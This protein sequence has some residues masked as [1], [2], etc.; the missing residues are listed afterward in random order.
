MGDWP[1]LRDYGRSIAVVMGTW[2][3]A[4]L[5]PV[6]A[7]EHSLRRMEQLLA[8]PLC[9]WPRERIQVL[10]NVPS[11]GDLPDR[12]ITAFDSVADVAV[13]YFV[14]HGQISP[15]DQLCLGLAQSRPEPNRRA[16]TSLRF[17]DV[18]QALQESI[19][20]VKIVILDC[21]FAGLA[22]RGAMAGDVLDL[23]VGTGAYT[24]AA[25]SAY[26]TAWYEDEPGLNS[27]Q[28]Y[29]TKYLADLVEKGIAG[30]P[31]MLRIDPLF[32]QLR[33][34]L[35]TDGRPVPYSRA[36]ND[37]REYVFAY[38]A[39]P[40]EVQ[41]DP[42]QELARLGQQFERF[43][44]AT[45]AEVNALKAEA[46]EREEELARLR[47]LLASSGPRNAGQQRQLESA[48]DEATRRLDDTRAAQAALST[49]DPEE[50]A[51]RRDRIEQLQARLRERAAAQ[52]WEA[53]IDLSGELT[54][55]DPSAADPDGLANTARH[56]ISRR[57]QTQHTDSPE[58]SQS[59][60]PSRPEANGDISTLERTADPEQA[61]P[62][63]FHAADLQ[64]GMLLSEAGES[65]HRRGT[66]WVKVWPVAN[67]IIAW[68]VFLTMLTLTIGVLAGWDSWAWLWILTPGLFCTAH[69]VGTVTD[70]ICWGSSSR[71]AVWLFGLQC[72]TELILILLST[73]VLFSA[74]ASTFAVITVLITTGVVSTWPGRAKSS[75]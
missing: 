64:P 6:P 69:I 9:G 72:V 4:F 68:C 61:D 1:P 25:T 7:A 17:A 26:T 67:R 40:P 55:L 46:A 50:V 37:A 13:F 18:R 74:S 36:V 10:A 63:L 58:P 62:A 66:N 8:G 22:T 29:F 53:V 14:G 11:P 27:P 43:K 34:N 65:A 59:G 30:Q 35:A 70:H 73:H 54:K 48:I 38:N 12:L 49:T 39:A 45:G 51:Q 42:E 24:M 20:A 56:H 2:D 19:A 33:V 16:A 71:L 47:E 21:C 41:R 15:D 44:A 32:R 28:T 31:A 60:P 52:A 5:E 23:T 57:Q 75:A 3:Y